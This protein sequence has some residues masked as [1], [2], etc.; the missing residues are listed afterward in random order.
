[1]REKKKVGQTEATM[2]NLEVHSE[3]FRSKGRGVKRGSGG[4]RDDR[5]HGVCWQ[6]VDVEKR[7]LRASLPPPRSPRPA[8]PLPPSHPAVPALSPV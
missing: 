1:M 6:G 4:Q 2:K 8:P 3:G 5:W 7:C